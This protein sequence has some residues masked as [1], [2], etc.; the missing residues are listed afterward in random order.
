MIMIMIMTIGGRRTRYSVLG[1]GLL[2]AID[3][4]PTAS[5][6]GVDSDERPF[7]AG[8]VLPT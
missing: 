5:A 7:K 8:A 1:R 6:Y 4:V 3:V 2:A